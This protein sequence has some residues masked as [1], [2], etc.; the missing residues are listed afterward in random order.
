MSRRRTV[1]S[2][3][4]R[5]GE[6]S[7]GIDGGLSVLGGNDDGGRLQKVLLLERLN[8]LADRGIHKREF[9][10]QS[11]RWCSC[12][13]TVAALDS[14]FDQF[15]TDA[16]GLEVHSENLGYWRLARTQVCLAVDPIHYRVGFQLVIA[17]DGLK[18]GG[19]IAPSNG[20]ATARLDGRA[21]EV[22]AGGL[23][24]RQG[25]L[26]G[27]YFRR[28]VV[29]HIARLSGSSRAGNRGINGVLIRPRGV[30]AGGVNHPVNRIRPN[31]IPGINRSA[32]G[33][34]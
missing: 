4:A 3:V 28:L 18:I 22:R 1:G 9:T 31:E 13:V 21:V 15:L 26:I 14:V 24:T 30:A 33:R 12:G 19:P 17:L 5:N 2:S 29:V 23:D 11:R 34:L 10:R 20:G 8:H 32:R 25:N 27:I 16:N 7:I 6:E